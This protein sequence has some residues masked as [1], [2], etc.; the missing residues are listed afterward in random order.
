MYADL[1]LVRGL[2]LPNTASS[3]RASGRCAPPSTHS[4][5][6]VR[7]SPVPE[8]GTW[9][10][11]LPFSSPLRYDMGEQVPVASAGEIVGQGT[12]T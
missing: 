12:L 2:T 5:F 9:K 6:T 11:N 4:S 3:L 1:A 8:A 7:S 10:C